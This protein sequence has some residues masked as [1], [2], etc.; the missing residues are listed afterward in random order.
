MIMF[1]GPVL[2]KTSVEVSRHSVSVRRT[3]VTSDVTANTFFFPPPFDLGV[4]KA[5]IRSHG[6]CVAK[7]LSS[8]GTVF[9]RGLVYL[10]FSVRN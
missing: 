4:F 9:P 7:K 2:S 6:N 8:T 3:R 5:I 10:D 1:K